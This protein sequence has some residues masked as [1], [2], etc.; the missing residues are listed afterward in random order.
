MT[1]TSKELIS[2]LRDAVNIANSDAE[3]E[4]ETVVKMSD[5]TLMLYINLGL[6]Q[7]YPSAE[8]LDDAPDGSSA[9]IVM[10]AKKELYLKLAVLDAP[11]YDLTADNNNQLHRSQR[12]D[13]YM[14]LAEAA[15]KDYEDWLEN[16]DTTDPVTGIS[17]VSS[18]NSYVYRRHFSQRN[19]QTAPRP[20]V[21][22]KI[23]ETTTESIAF[24]WSS[25]LNDRFACY[26]VYV[27]KGAVVNPYADGA[28]VKDHLNDGAVLVK[29]TSD[30]RDTG[31]TITGLL[32]DTEYH[33]AV[34]SVERNG[35][36]GFKEVAVTTLAE[37]ESEDTE[38]TDVGDLL[39]G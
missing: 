20:K 27:S 21:R 32:P 28:T 24:E 36:W 15:Q 39:N 30:F 11:L 18:Y 25:V 9:A 12:F 6:S 14:K 13:H 29:S 17:G 35:L 19:Y 16:G 2:L 7:A 37:P 33:I 23:R 31:H 3:V 22:V 38:V 1:L 4:D 26:Y 10:V 8:S 34:F 5:E